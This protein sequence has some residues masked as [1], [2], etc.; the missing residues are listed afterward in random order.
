MGRE[1]KMCLSK[2]YVEKA[3][4]KEFLMTDIASVKVDGDK[5]VLKNLFGD[6]KIFSANILEIDFTANSLR[7]DITK[8]SLPI[9]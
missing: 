6:K 8:G 9:D 2:A 4:K 1:N 7:L 5:L 3:G